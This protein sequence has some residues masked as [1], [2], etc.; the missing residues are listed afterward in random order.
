MP[1]LLALIP[2]LPGP[3]LVAKQIIRSARWA[4][5]RL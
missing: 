3:R 1:K 4:L 2:G 5:L